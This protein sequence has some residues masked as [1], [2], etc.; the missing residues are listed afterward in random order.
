MCAVSFAVCRP[1]ARLD[2]AIRLLCTTALPSTV[3]TFAPV[4]LTRNLSETLMESS[5]LAFATPILSDAR[6]IVVDVFPVT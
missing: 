2:I 3:T 6:R 1:T 5:G 4:A